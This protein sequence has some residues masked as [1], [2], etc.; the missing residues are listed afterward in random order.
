MARQAAR[1]SE[2]SDTTMPMTTMPDDPI[3]S[4]G[5]HKMIAREAYF[6]AEQRGFQGG[7][8]MVDWLEAEEEID[9]MLNKNL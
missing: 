5:R 7:D 9:R 1:Q 3:I 2:K 6:R 4:L 8:P